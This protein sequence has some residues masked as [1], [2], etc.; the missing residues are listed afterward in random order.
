[1]FFSTLSV[2]ALTVCLVLFA[3]TVQLKA[4]TIGDTQWVD[5]DNCTGEG[6]GPCMKQQECLS[7]DTECKCIWTDV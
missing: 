5:N 7:L 2:V 6:T 1:M 4:D 3:V